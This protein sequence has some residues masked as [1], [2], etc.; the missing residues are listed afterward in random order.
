MAQ[1]LRGEKKREVS[2]FTINIIFSTGKL[3]VNNV[4]ISHLFKR[5]NILNF[6]CGMLN[7]VNT[8]FLSISTRKDLEFIT[9]EKRMPHVLYT[10][11]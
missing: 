11:H 7:D 8:I 4:F 5:C 9:W 10:Y 6:T 1:K 3:K 2:Y